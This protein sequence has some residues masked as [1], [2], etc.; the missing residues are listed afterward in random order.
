MKF[1]LNLYDDDPSSLEESKRRVLRERDVLIRDLRGLLE[2]ET[3]STLQLLVRDLKVNRFWGILSGLDGDF[4]RDDVSVMTE[5]RA[6]T[7]KMFD[8]RTI[9]RFLD[10]C[11]NLAM[12]VPR[13]GGA[14]G[15]VTGHN[16]LYDQF[17]RT[18]ESMFGGVEVVSPWFRSRLNNGRFWESLSGMRRIVSGWGYEPVSDVLENH[19]GDLDVEFVHRGLFLARR[20]QGDLDRGLDFDLDYV[21]DAA[22]V[23][24][25]EFV[26]S[27]HEERGNLELDEKVVSELVGPYISSRLGTHLGDSGYVPRFPAK[28]K[29]H[30]SDFFGDE[31]VGYYVVNSERVREQ[32][33]GEVTNQLYTFADG[34]DTQHLKS[35]LDAMPGVQGV[36][37]FVFSDGMDYDE[38][39]RLFGELG[40]V[41]ENPRVYL[42]LDARR[43]VFVAACTIR[44]RSKKTRRKTKIK[45][46][47]Y[48]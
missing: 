1:R 33:A 36:M 20:A 9:Q 25:G 28:S 2:Y 4:E 3:D 40:Y 45:R 11:V 13:Q 18:P 12:L 35:I 8:Q 38:S 10:V 42:G 32:L 31:F 47:R 6:L 7:K 26:R 15:L 29:S 46:R 17:V 24:Y 37:D 21:S 5:K 19:F 27:L 14:P 41:N 48:R 44:A 30:F 23:R 43:R 34:G 39:S 16:I 22:V